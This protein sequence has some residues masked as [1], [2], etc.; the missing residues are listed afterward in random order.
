MSSYIAND[1]L[2]AFSANGGDTIRTTNPA[3]QAIIGSANALS[4]A[5]VGLLLDMYPCQSGLC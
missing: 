2:Q 3:F 1:V 4:Q 5:D